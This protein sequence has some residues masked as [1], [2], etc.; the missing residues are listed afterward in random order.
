M[1]NEVNYIGIPGHKKKQRLLINWWGQLFLGELKQW[2]KVV[3]NHELRVST[4]I[5]RMVGSK[6]FGIE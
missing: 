1:R 4:L 6:E 2:A 5:D 3:K